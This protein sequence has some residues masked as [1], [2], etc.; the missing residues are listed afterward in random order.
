MLFALRIVAQT[1]I[2]F[3]LQWHVVPV[4]DELD[5]ANDG[6]PQ[7]SQR[8]RRKA[9]NPSFRISKMSRKTAQ[10]QEKTEQP[11]TQMNRRQRKRATKEVDLNDEAAG[12]SEKKILE[13]AEDLFA[14]LLDLSTR[15][16]I[17]A[18]EH[19]AGKPIRT[20]DEVSCFGNI[21]IY[22]YKYIYIYYVYNIYCP[23]IYIYIYHIN[24]INHVFFV[25]F[26]FTLNQ[27]LAATAVG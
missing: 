16:D 12:T 8:K 18:L 15:V 7:S 19:N 22:K 20:L 2:R 5:F 13:M 4:M 3:R 25:A 10:T 9:P 17:K 26:T 14:D 24:L 21:C 6:Q 23:Y 1:I 27:V 11:E